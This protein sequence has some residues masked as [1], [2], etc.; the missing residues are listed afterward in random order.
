MSAGFLHHDTMAYVGATPWHR[1]GNNLT[2]GADIGVWVEESG[3]GYPVHHEPVYLSDGTLIPDRFA[4]V[5]GDIRKVFTFASE[6]RKDIQPR[7]ILEFFRDLSQLPLETAGTLGDGAIVWALARKGEGFSIKGED[8]LKN[9]LL[10]STSYDGSMA[11]TGRW[12]NVRVVCQ[13]TL[14]MSMGDKAQVKV[15]H[16][17]I[18]DETAVKVQLG[19][20]EETNASFERAANLLAERKVTQGEVENI[21][22]TLF[23]SYKPQTKAEIDAKAAPVLTTQSSNVIQD[24]VR[25]MATSPGANL[26]TSR[27]TAW[28]VLNGIT[29][30]V[31]H[32]ARAHSD[33]NRLKSAWFGNGDALKADAFKLTRE[34][35]P[36]LAA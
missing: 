9:Y 11:T 6:R 4:V 28:G 7:E 24:V 36:A 23:A 14:R 8:Y 12:T 10:L 22:L 27:G 31:D 30:Y 13:N 3:T 33:D 16:T 17:S 1:S 32:A 35:V 26:D 29:H 2:P 5:R 19:V 34:L 20:Y 25:S 15:R 21:L 18:F